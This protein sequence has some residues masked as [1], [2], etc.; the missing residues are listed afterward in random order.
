MEATRAA[1]CSRL[2]NT[3]KGESMAKAAAGG[4]GADGWVADELRTRHQGCARADGR[5]RPAPRTEVR[6]AAVLPPQGAR[7][8]RSGHHAA[9]QL[10]ALARPLPD[11]QVARR[12]PQARER[13]TVPRQ[14]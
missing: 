1:C 8:V 7:R 11:P 13:S 9:H 14:V 3:R 2:S 6:D 5:A 4:D 12:S 10:G